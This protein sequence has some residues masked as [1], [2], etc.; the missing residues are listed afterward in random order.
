METSGFLASSVQALNEL[1]L[2]NQ[3]TEWIQPNQRSKWRKHSQHSQKRL[4]F[5]LVRLAYHQT[6]VMG[7]CPVSLIRLT[8]L[9]FKER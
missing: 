9:T 8:A 4:L 6:Q 3:I 5:L 2:R 1:K 7:A